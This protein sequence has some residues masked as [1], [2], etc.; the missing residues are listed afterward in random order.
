MNA[1]PKL[2]IWIRLVAIVLLTVS[3]S[4]KPRPKLFIR[5][6]KLLATTKLPFWD[7]CSIIVNARRVNCLRQTSKISVKIGTYSVKLARKLQQ[8][9]ILLSYR[10]DWGD[11]TLRLFDHHSRLAEKIEKLWI[12][13]GSWI[14]YKGNDAEK[15]FWGDP[16]SRDLG[17]M[18]LVIKF[19]FSE[20][21]PGSKLELLE[22]SETWLPFFLTY[23]NFRM[24]LSLAFG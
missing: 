18:Y 8:I 16:L 4:G 24:N 6:G 1:W 20:P 17:Y 12:I 13:Q 2:Q 21:R 11:L 19:F 7:Y 14:I 3:V 22:A 5:G 9:Q 10:L 23:S 15:H